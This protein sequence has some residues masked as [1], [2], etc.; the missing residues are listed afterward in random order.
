MY[1]EPEI[2]SSFSINGLG[3][4][5]YAIIRA[6]SPTQVIELGALNGYSSVCILQALTV[7]TGSSRLDTIDL[8]EKYPFNN[9]SRAA[10]QQNVANCTSKM[11][12]SGTIH[13]VHQWDVFSSLDK[14]SMLI[15]T[16]RP[17][18]F[19]DLSNTAE[20]IE[21]MI[22]TFSRFGPILFEGGSVERDNVE[23]MRI[24]KKTP[25]QE[26]RSKGKNYVVVNH[27]Y[28]SLSLFY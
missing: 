27:A 14:I 17:M 13:S 8:F 1:L 20:I 9:C 12:V 3:E 5:I 19:I 24:Y 2:E 15:N 25:L 26:L 28:P 10:Y 11:S 23:W 7:S 4:S 22:E 21:T 18:F 16:E 6:Y